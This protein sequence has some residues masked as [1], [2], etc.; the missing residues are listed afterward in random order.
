M[1]IKVLGIKLLL[2]CAKCRREMEVAKMLESSIEGDLI[3]VHVEPCENCLLQA[4]QEG[5]KKGDARMQTEA[6]LR[7]EAEA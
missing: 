7:T 4:E 3:W 6:R 1:G 5:I 2:V